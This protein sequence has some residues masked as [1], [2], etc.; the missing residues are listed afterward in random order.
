MKKRQ[1]PVDEKILKAAV[2]QALKQ[3]RL[4]FYSPLASGI[5]NYRKSVIPRYSI[6]DELATIVESA[7]NEKY[8]ALTAKAKRMLTKARR[9]SRQTSARQPGREAS[10]A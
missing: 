5:L 6:S 8:P 3:P 7:L 9:S 4:A 1:E 10:T 2:K